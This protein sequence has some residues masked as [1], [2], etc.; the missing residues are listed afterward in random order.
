MEFKAVTKLFCGPK[1]SSDQLGLN[2]EQ[3]AYL[4]HDY[5]NL[6]FQAY[7]VYRGRGSLTNNK[8]VTSFPQQFPKTPHNVSL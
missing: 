7:L 8:K 6:I 2:A 3:Q 4:E 1:L 5:R